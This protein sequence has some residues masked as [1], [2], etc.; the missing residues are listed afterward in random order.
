MLD[1]LPVVVLRQIF[2]FLDIGER[3]RARSTCKAWRFTVDTWF[4]QQSLCIYSTVYPYNERWCCSNQRV[5]EKEMFHLK[6]DRVASH[7]LDWKMEFFRNLQ[8]LYLYEMGDK[9]EP[10][11]EELNQVTSLKVLMIEESRIYLRKLSSSSLAWLSIKCFCCDHIELDTPNLSSLILS[12]DHRPEEHPG[13]LDFHSPRKVRHLQCIEFNSNLDQLKGLE[14]LACQRITFDFKLD[15][16]QSLTRT[17]LWSFDAFQLVRNEKNRLNRPD[18]QVVASGF[19]EG[20]VTSRPILVQ[21]EFFCRFHRLPGDDLELSESYLRRAELNKW[22][23][24]G[25]TPWNF[26]VEYA[27]LLPFVGKIPR[28]FFSKLRI[29]SFI[30]AQLP[31]NGVPEIDQV[32]LVELVERSQPEDLELNCELSEAT[33]QR[34]SH[35]QSIKYLRVTVNEKLDGLLGLKNLVTLK[36]FKA[37]ISIGFICLLFKELKLFSHLW[38]KPDPRFGNNPNLWVTFDNNRLEVYDESAVEYPFSICFKR[39]TRCRYLDELV[40]EVRKLGETHNQ[41]FID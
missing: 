40:E 39:K 1:R 14:T 38:L 32:A 16:F 23:L 10:F 34:L 17:E 35:I 20:T 28:N 12:I 29:S 27:T 15:E 4:D 33:L 36:V 41:L 3:L 11:L 5:L 18:L 31:L 6:F 8:K 2:C 19:E 25:S 13:T 7:R 26:T 22:N 21:E 37:R 24:L 30:L 9:T